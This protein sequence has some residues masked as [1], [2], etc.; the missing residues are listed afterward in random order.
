MAEAAAYRRA[1][2][3]AAWLEGG[4]E[5]DGL[6]KLL[7]LLALATAFWGGLAPPVQFALL[8]GVTLG[9][10]EKTYA[11]RVAFDQRVFASWATQWQV[12]ERADPDAALTEFDQTLGRMHLRSATGQATRGLDER[13]AGACALLRKQVTCLV[14]QFFA[15]LAAAFLNLSWL[16]LPF[17]HGI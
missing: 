10:V 5:L 13:I 1:G 7:T 15:M 3:T 16:G 11:V 12:T 2:L 14:L 17:H 6:S 8:L 4:K 9:A